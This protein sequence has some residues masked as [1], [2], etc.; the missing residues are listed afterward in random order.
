MD[1]APRRYLE[2]LPLD[3]PIDCGSFALTREEIID[4]ARKFDPQPQHLGEAEAAATA[5][6]ALVASGIHSQAAALGLIV[7]ATTGVAAMFGLALHETRFFVPVRPD[8]PHAVTARW[9]EARPSASKPGQGV[10]RIEG[11]A[12]NPDGQ[13]ALTF[14]ITMIVARRPE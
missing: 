5:F 7:R 8:V 11:Q 6:G 1:T 14:G 13:T 9:T 4:F 3:A 12:V 2:D 10:A